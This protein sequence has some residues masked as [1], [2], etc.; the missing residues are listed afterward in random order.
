MKDLRRG[1]E[2]ENDEPVAKAAKV[3]VPDKDEKRKEK[4]DPKAADI[5]VQNISG[6]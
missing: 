4:R 3:V 1:E 2:V 5:M 6:K